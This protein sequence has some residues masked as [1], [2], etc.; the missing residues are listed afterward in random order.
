MTWWDMC[1]ANWSPI[2]FQ[3][4]ILVVI[5][6][7]DCAQTV[8][9]VVCCTPV[10]TR[11]FWRMCSCYLTTPKSELSLV[12]RNFDPV[13][14]Y[15]CVHVALQ[16]ALGSDCAAYRVSVSHSMPNWNKREAFWKN[17]HDTVYYKVFKLSHAE[18]EDVIRKWECVHV[19]VFLKKF[20][21][22]Y[23]VPDC[24]FFRSSERYFKNH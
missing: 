3:S 22:F 11:M 4:S 16:N 18:K 20:L 5:L 12:T 15:T 6:K 2:G 21:N 14:R 7:F 8:T 23:I 17:E 24:T 9:F 10:V 19:H 1:G 13:V